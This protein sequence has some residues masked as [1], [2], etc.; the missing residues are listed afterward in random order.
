MYVKDA[1]ILG[2][3]HIGLS[4]AFYSSISVFSQPIRLI[5]NCAC[6]NL[7]IATQHTLP[8]PQTIIILN[9]RFSCIFKE[10]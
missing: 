1:L 2:L 8:H 6:V 9:T 10:F 5:L 4:H 7:L 3:S